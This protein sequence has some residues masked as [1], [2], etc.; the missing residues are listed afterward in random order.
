MSKHTPRFYFSFRSPYAWMAVRQIQERLPS[1]FGLMQLIP[2]WEPDSV[3][4]EL[5]RAHSATVLYQPMSRQK[6]M[7]IL[8]DVKRLAARFGYRLAWPIDDNPWWDLPHLAYIKARRLG[9]GMEFLHAAFNA[10]WEQGRNICVEETVRELALAVGLE[11]DSLSSAPS[12]GTVRDEGAGELLKAWNDDVFGI[13]FWVHGFH[14]FWGLDRLADFA[15]S[16]PAGMRDGAAIPAP[17]QAKLG[18]YD[19]D[20]AGGCG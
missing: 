12:D 15:A 1:L 5:L 20:T 11:P 6:H 13:P 14:K 8:Q 2:Y 19:S 7:Y 18:C 16:L 17:V 4:Q 3:T 10:R 9:R